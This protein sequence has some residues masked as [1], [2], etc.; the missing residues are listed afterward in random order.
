[1]MKLSEAYRQKFEAQIEELNARLA[2]VRAQAKRLAADAQIVAHEELADTDRK[3]AELQA[4]LTA[5]RSAG[6]GAWQD[7]KGGVESAWRDVNQAAGR[8]LQRFGSKPA[9]QPEP[10]APTPQT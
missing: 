8:A 1:M 5:L 6:D 7:M 10:A 4:R 9:A 2:V 3:L